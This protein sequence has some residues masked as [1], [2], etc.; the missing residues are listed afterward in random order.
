MN[1]AFSSPLCP[2][3]L[4]PLCL[5]SPPPI[6][7]SR[8]SPATM[9]KE[10]TA[11]LER[12]KKATTTGKAKER[13]SS[14]GGSS[15]RS[16]LPHGWVQGDWICSTITERDLTEM[17]NKGLIP[18]G[19]ARLPG[20][21]W[22]PQPQEGECVLLATH[23]DRGFSLPSSAFFRGFLNF[24]GAQLHHFT[25]NTIVYLAAFISLCENFLGSWPHWVFSSIFSLGLSPQG[26]LSEMRACS[27]GP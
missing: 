20:N 12:T 23:V 14:R 11:A 13:V 18:H 22:H 8:A 24:F 16:R 21:E 25:P 6:H 7:S 26:A 17:A 4:R 9:V 19:A 5:L 27:L 1:S 2:L 15:S 3:C 10:K